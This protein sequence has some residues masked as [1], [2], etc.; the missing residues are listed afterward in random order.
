M[1]KDS[2][3]SVNERPASSRRRAF[4]TGIRDKAVRDRRRR[5]AAEQAEL[6]PRVRQSLLELRETLGVGS[7]YIVGSVLSPALWRESSDVD[8][9]VSGCSHAV[10]DVMKA[11]EEA[12]G[13][14]VDV[15]DLD[16]HPFPESF[17]RCGVKVYG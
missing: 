10:L 4:D 13:R 16:R 7:A 2:T 15:I 14:D 12:T 17:I 9:A 6:L 1:E 5:L 11:L 8:V 3:R